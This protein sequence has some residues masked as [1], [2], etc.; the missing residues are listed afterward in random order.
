M[1]IYDSTLIYFLQRKFGDS[2]PVP[3][4]QDC[5]VD[6][7]K[8]D[9]GEEKNDHTLYLSPETLSMEACILL[10]QELWII[11]S[12]LQ[13]WDSR[14][15]AAIAGGENLQVL[16][17]QISTIYDLPMMIVDVD[18]NILAHTNNSWNAFI[19]VHGRKMY[20]ESIDTSA[21][22]LRE[23]LSV[24]LMF[25]RDFQENTR[26]KGFYP[27]H[28]MDKPLGICRNFF[29]N[30]VCIVFWT[31]MGLFE[32]QISSGER[33]LLEYLFSVLDQAVPDTYK[34]KHMIHENL[35]LHEM[36][37]AIVREAIGNSGIPAG[38]TEMTAA[39][40]DK[41]Q[42]IQQFLELL[43]P[44]S[45]EA[46]DCCLLVTLSFFE[47][48]GAE[49]SA[50]H[51]CRL[52]EEKYQPSIAVSEEGRIYWIINSAK[53][54][55]LQ[56]INVQKEFLLNI[57]N[58]YFCRAGISDPCPQ[59]QLLSVYVKEAVLALQV[60][61]RRHPHYWYHFY[62]ESVWDYILQHLT[63]EIPTDQLIHT[64]IQTIKEYDRIHGTA[65]LKSLKEYYRNDK[66]ISQT[67]AKLYMHRTS[68]IRQLK[69][70]E[71]IIHT[72]LNNDYTAGLYLQLSLLLE[73]NT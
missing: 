56:D 18:F 3:E 66:N 37:S 34:K 6:C 21:D 52:L 38:S 13:S 43:Y 1:K 4:T 23:I 8:I 20:E 63:D 50:P 31:V 15:N 72:D 53:I 59:L 28:Y 64:G 67:A 33:H 19:D 10:L 12:D 16:L 30:D 61:F 14:L 27:V 65:Y 40:P 54:P 49:S 57:T 73:E 42:L 69:R 51:V 25:T 44:Y 62:R 48:I 47:S 32:E 58:E 29:I 5:P 45:W 55:S 68:L 41:N 35:Q 26:R 70:I 39:N 9:N 24:D 46:S 17:N 7:I 36:F 60:G 22:R 2:L 71:S 11:L